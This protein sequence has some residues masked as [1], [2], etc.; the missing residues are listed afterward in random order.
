MTVWRGREIFDRE[1]VCHTFSSAEVSGFSEF[2]QRVGDRDLATLSRSDIFVPEVQ[3]RLAR[4]REELEHGSGVVLLRALPTA[5]WRES[6]S[7]LVFWALARSLGTPVSQSA[8]G[9]RLLHVRDEGFAPTDPRFR[10]PMSSKRL[11]FHTDRCDVIGFLCLC[12]ALRGGDTFVVSSET[13]YEE[14]E[15]RFPSALAMLSQ[16]F[17]YLRH[18]VDRG[19][20]KLYC[21]LPVF[22]RHEG[23]FA[24][25]FLRVLIDRADQDA[26][27]PNL[28]SAQREALDVLEAV[29]EEASLHVSLSLES[30]DILLLNNWT[31]FHRRSAFDDSRE[32]EQHRHLL[33]IWLSMDNSRP[34]A[35]CFVD[36][37]G[38]TSAGAIRGG[39]KPL[40]ESEKEL[41]RER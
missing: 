35:P 8:D 38:A 17:P 15:R 13:L 33:R 24:A 12:P 21:E 34:I 27:T 26:K 10:G 29:A 36:H 1:D 28:T 31:T 2:L 14:L 40:G 30:G 7:A 39:M 32:I 16:P 20:T 18:T 37:F 25:H 11:S 4:V 23:A 22:S 3:S 41:E 19:N 9:Q 5:I 6:S